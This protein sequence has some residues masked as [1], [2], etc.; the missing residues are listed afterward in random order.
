T[1]ARDLHA[2][3]RRPA[4]AD[5]RRQDAGLDVEPRRWVGRAD[6][7]RGV[8]PR[9]GARGARAGAATARERAMKNGIPAGPMALA[10]GETQGG[11]VTGRARPLGASAALVALSAV[12]GWAQAPAA[13][14]P[15]STRPHVEHLASP[16]L[17][18]RATGSPGA[19]AAA[20]YIVGQLRALGASPL[21][22]RDD[23]LVPFEYTA[24]MR[25]DGTTLTITRGDATERFD[26]PADVQGLSFSDSTEVSGEV[27]FAGYGLAMPEGAGLGYDSYATLDVKDKIVVVLRYFPEDADADLRAALARYS[28]LRYK[29]LMARERGAKGLIVVTGPRSP[30]AGTT[31]P[32]AYDTSSAGS[33][34][35]AASVSGEVAARLFAGHGQSLEEVQ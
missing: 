14:A 35:A 34:I 11:L 33:G 7:L 32:L 4:R 31:V 13:D 22:G 26:Q 10:G 8:E 19:D 3:V 27:A 23:F 12:P 6:L 24:R 25:D 21:P 15:P 20:P 17:E 29:A 1:G 5:T 18:G 16:A 2:G 28:G 30:N 9:E